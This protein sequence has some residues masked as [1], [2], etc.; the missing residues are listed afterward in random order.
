MSSVA[1][2]SRLRSTI[3]LVM[4]GVTIFYPQNLVDTASIS[5]FVKR[6]LEKPEI[7]LNFPLYVT[8]FFCLGS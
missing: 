3:L 5:L 2:N 7:R 4:F 1:P 6:S 8:C